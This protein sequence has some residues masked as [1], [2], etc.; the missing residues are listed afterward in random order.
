[1]PKFKREWSNQNLRGNGQTKILKERVTP[2]FKRR[3]SDQ[4][5]REE[6]HTKF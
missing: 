2:N 3:E 5:L 4:I 1:M 6:S